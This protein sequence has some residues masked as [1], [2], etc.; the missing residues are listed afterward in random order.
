MS[1]AVRTS[2]TQAIAVGTIALTLIGCGGSDAPGRDPAPQPEPAPTPQPSPA[3]DLI[4]SYLGGGRSELIRDVAVD[5]AGNLYLTGGTTSGDF[6]T[7]AGAFDRTA[8][9]NMDVFLAKYDPSGSLVCATLLGGPNYDRTYALEIA[10]DGAVILAGRAGPGF[11]TTDGVVQRSFGG[12]EVVTRLYGAQDGFVAKISA[13]CTMLRWSTFFGGPGREV[14]RDVDV[15]GSGV[16]VAMTAIERPA[17]YVPSSALQPTLR[18]PSDAAAA[19]LSSDGRAVLWATYLGGSGADAGGPSIRVDN[20]QQAHVLIDTHSDDAPVTAGAAQ[21]RFKG[22]GGDLYLVKLAAD[23]RSRVYATYLG[24]NGLEGGETHN[25]ALFPDGAAVV[26]AFT[27][28]TDWPVTPGAVQPNHADGGA[29]GDAVLAIVSPSG[30]ALTAVT[31]LGGRGEDA[32]EGV[33]IDSQ[34]RIVVSGSTNAANW[35]T[36]PDAVQSSS[37]GAGDGFVAILDRALSRLVYSTLM[38]GSRGDGLR[39][40]A[41]APGNRLLAG[42]TSSSPNAPV[43]DA[44]QPSRA[45]PDDGLWVLIQ[46]P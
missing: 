6:P 42:G 19:K 17:P 8:N 32:F 13:D 30:S 23:G 46:A 31:Y 16:Y 38:G 36:T 10:P 4:V 43:A 26:A 5:A 24:G 35:P 41:V 2:A 40:I 34:Q 28:S 7:T 18:G 12:D 21:T 9:G 14:V 45:G 25:L 1:R 44:P 29:R 3:G 39:S 15:D 22:G 11:P 27:R 33:A 20:N 37:S